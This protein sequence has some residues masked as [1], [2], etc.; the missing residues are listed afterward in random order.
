MRCSREKSPVN[1]ARAP[2][3]KASGGIRVPASHAP[4]HNERNILW[5][6]CSPC[7]LCVQE[8]G[9]NLYL[10]SVWEMPNLSVVKMPYGE[11]VLLDTFPLKIM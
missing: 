7:N 11:M 8:E 4:Y 3:H 1:D 6:F 5:V 10:V 2:A 9:D